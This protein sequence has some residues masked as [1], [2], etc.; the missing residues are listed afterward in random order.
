MT[1]VNIHQMIRNERDSESIDLGWGR[2]TWLVGTELMPGAEQT[3]GLVTIHPGQRNPLHSH[4][5]CE[6]LLYVI[7]GSCEHRLG[8]E[9][10][11][12]L[13]GS[14]IRIPRNIPHWARCT[15]IEP[16]VAVIAFS[17]P[18]RQTTMHEEQG[19]G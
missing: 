18:D 14:V 10:T 9:T 13:P 17:S 1:G 19:I 16:L 7:S 6:E 15:S 2:I 12:L 5:N 11:E 4:P 3:L 8:G